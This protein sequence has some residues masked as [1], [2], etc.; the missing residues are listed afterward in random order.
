MKTR[1]DGDSHESSKI[2]LSE[3]KEKFT[4]KEP[5]FSIDGANND[6]EFEL[7]VKSFFGL[8]GYPK[9]VI[10]LCVVTKG[11]VT[12]E[13]NITLNFKNGESVEEQIKRIEVWKKGVNFAITGQHV[14]LCLSKLSLRQLRRLNEKEK[15]S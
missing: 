7:D 3:K 1:Y 6:G 11:K 10:V 5:T 15:G 13:N 9:K 8:S 14:G 12:D 4:E 2:N